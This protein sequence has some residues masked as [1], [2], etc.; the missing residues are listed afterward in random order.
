M[1]ISAS[2]T[3]V[4]PSRFN[5]PRESGNGGYSSG[6]FAALIDGPAEVSLRA[7]VPLDTPLAVD[8]REGDE[9]R[10]SAGE[11]LV[12]TARPAP[13]LELA[14]PPPVAPG[15]AR[16]AAAHYGGSG[17][18]LLDR[19]YVCGLER[20][21][22]FGVFAAPVYGRQVVATPWTPPAWAADDAGDVRAE[23]IWAA[24]DCPTYFGSYVAEPFGLSMLARM[25]ARIDAPVTAGTEHVVMAW[26]IGT[27]GRKREAAAAVLTGD[28]EVLAVAKA[29]LIELRS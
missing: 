18:G 15:D 28:G 14:V 19:C 5:G 7:P 9:V 13:E 29:L 1:I 11:T 4:I 25:Q 3:I 8:H 17:Y 16:A 23:H 24:L 10:A 12:G 20:E 26:P 21:H 2:Q 22:S 6:A 27:D